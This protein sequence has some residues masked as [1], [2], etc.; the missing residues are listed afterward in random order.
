MRNKFSIQ[1][2]IMCSMH[3]IEV[4]GIAFADY[5]ALLAETVGKTRV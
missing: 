1:V 2:L 5:M 4:K 3:I